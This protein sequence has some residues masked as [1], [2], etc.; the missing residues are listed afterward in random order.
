MASGYIAGGS[1]AGVVVAFL[2]FVPEF[3]KS[4]D[5]ESRFAELGNSFN[6]TIALLG[7]AALIGFAALV[8]LG[9][10]F[11]PPKDDNGN[12]NLEPESINRH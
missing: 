7:F 11:K 2:E 8:G 10:V 9:K 1:L 5:L 12:S 4:I 3:K 6:N